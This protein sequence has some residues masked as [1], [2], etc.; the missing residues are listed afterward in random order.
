[1]N[2]FSNI[3]IT[4]LVVI[5]LL[6]LLVVGPERLPEMGRNLAKFLR[7]IRKLYENLTS[8]IGPELMSL[9]E[10]TREIRE[11]V[12]SVRSIPQDMV[13]TMVTSSGMDETIQE[14][15]DV[16]GDLKAVEA[17]VSNTRKMIKDPL[18]SA[19]SAAR[20]SLTQSSQKTAAAETPEKAEQDHTSDSTNEE[21]DND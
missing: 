20:S 16:S 7:D 4:E 15:K 17:S 3:G 6:A 18:D 14:L 8:E 13:K 10:T 19:V 5:L 9:Q 11:S 1:M 21:K 12:E 2:I